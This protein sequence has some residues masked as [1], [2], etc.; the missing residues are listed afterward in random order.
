MARS[1]N[2]VNFIRSLKGASETRV[3]K[4]ALMDC[5]ELS[6]TVENE[7][8]DVVNGAIVYPPIPVFCCRIAAEFSY[9]I[10]GNSYSQTRYDKCGT[11]SETGCQCALYGEQGDKKG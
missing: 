3:H 5:N 2:D 11:T 9:L 1:R 7:D 6:D 10:L 8:A 4:S